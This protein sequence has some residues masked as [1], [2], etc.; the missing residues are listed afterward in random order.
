MAPL[1]IQINGDHFESMDF[2][3]IETEERD[4]LPVVDEVNINLENHMR[5]YRGLLLIYRLEFI[6]DHCKS[7]RVEALNMA[8]NYIKCNTYNVKDYTR[9]FKKMQDALTAEGT[10]THKLPQIDSAW[11]DTKIK[12]A[13]LRFERL[14]TDLKNYRCNGIKESIRRGQDDLGDHYLDCGEL[15]CAF[16]AFSK[17]RDYTMTHKNQI[18][19]CLNMIRVSIL[20]KRWQA[21]SSNV[22]RAENPPSSTDQGASTNPVVET[23]LNCA[24]GLYELNARKYK[25]AANHFLRANFEHF[26]ETAPLTVANHGPNFIG[27]SNSTHP[28]S[29]G[30]NLLGH[31]SSAGTVF[32]PTNSYRANSTDIYSWGGHWSILT[33]SNIAVYGSLCALATYSRDEL[34][35]DLVNSSAFKQFAELEPQLREAV[36]KFYE[37]KYAACLQILDSL[38]N[39]FRIDMFLAPHV[40]R[41]YRSIRSKAL[42][43]YFEPYSAADMHKMA[44]AFNTTVQELEKEIIALIYD[45]Q[46]KARIDSHNKILYAKDID[47]RTTIFERATKTGKLWQRQTRALITRSAILNSGICRAID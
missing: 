24:A 19:Q 41:L 21:V 27:H 33:P 40:E 29:S 35:N 39:I 9:L 46:I 17:S 45:G 36:Q 7:L 42:V 11:V 44:D 28:G 20:L 15:E 30:N 34:A 43:Q 18:I 8:I 13:G 10:P 38:K 12:Q 3:F 16:S 31:S 26:P 47:P 5:H 37:S 2:D 25:K 1:P 4:M 6:S 23:K 22:L 14:D 32:T